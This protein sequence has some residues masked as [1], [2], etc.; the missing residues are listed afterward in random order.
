VR[1]I[2]KN[3]DQPYGCANLAV[4][5]KK[6]CIV[7]M[8]FFVFLTKN[9]IRA[10]KEEEQAPPLPMDGFVILSKGFRKPKYRDVGEGLAPPCR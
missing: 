1:G 2:G 6:N 3:K 7:L 10:G 8:Q 4:K 5:S 9:Q